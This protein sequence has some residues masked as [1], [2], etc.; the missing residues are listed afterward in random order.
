MNVFLTG[1]SGFVASHLAVQC[2]NAGW[3]VRGS[4]R[5]AASFAPKFPCEEVRSL[6]LG[7][8]PPAALFSG[9]DAV[10]HCAWD[11]SAGAGDLNVR[12]T[13]LLAEHARQSGVTR[14]VFISS[15][16]AAPDAPTEYGQFKWKAETLFGTEVGDLV[17]RPGLVAGPGG[18]FGRIAAVIRRFPIVPLIAGGRVPVPLVAVDDLGQAVRR[19]LEARPA[20]PRSFDVFH[21]DVPTMSQLVRAVA[22]ALGVRRL[23]VPI[24]AGLC[25]APLRLVE[26]CG[27]RLPIVSDNV[28][29]AVRN[30]R[31]N[32]TP[33]LLTL[34]PE[35]QPW[36]SVVMEFGERLAHASSRSA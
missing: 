24:P 34:V 2:A 23:F 29:A 16:S 35:A 27:L 25:I 31:I 14:Q 3:I 6:S 21:P 7:T 28:R 9:C 10:V 33:D 32:R 20:R 19:L 5:D 1:L 17:V 26:W 13:R 8:R 18:L 12:G 22:R 30:R 4:V 11:V 36:Q 15:Y